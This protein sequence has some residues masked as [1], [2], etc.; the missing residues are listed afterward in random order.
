MIPTDK[1][2][3]LADKT[4]H[5]EEGYSVFGKVN[6]GIFAADKEIVEN[7]NKA[8]ARVLGSFEEE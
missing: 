4:S 3:E 5:K 7:L 8:E 2:K 1:L 6:L